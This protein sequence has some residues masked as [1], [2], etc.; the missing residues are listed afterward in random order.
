MSGNAPSELHLDEDAFLDLLFGARSS[1]RRRS[2]LA[3]L[4]A[5]ARCEGELLRHAADHERARTIAARVLGHAPPVSVRGNGIVAGLRSV[6]ERLFR[7]RPAFA[8]AAAA[9]VLAIVFLVPRPDPRDATLDPLLRWLPDATSL[10]EGRGTPSTPEEAWQDGLRS[11]ADR[12]PG[13][14]ARLLERG[15]ADG[16]LEVLRDVY[17]GSALAHSGQYRRAV[18]V[19]EAV[20]FANVP[21]PWLGESQWTLYVA[22]RG[23]SMDARADSVLASLSARQDSVGERARALRAH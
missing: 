11:Y 19:L 12:D 18:T 2:A 23:A 1:D 22:L 15:R 7:P 4:R 13:R 20:P 17:L 21:E 6:L 14:A 16:K 10:M 3:H 5:C 9:A 8:L